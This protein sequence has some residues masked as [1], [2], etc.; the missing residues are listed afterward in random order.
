MPTPQPTHSPVGCTRLGRVARKGRKPWQSWY[1]YEYY[2][3][4]AFFHSVRVRGTPF[5]GRIAKVFARHA[6]V[7]STGLRCCCGARAADDA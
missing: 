4:G 7:H 5:S 2:Y 3:C 1:A 6:S